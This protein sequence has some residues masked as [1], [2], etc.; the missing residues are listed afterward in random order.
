MELQ[1]VELDAV[2]VHAASSQDGV[3]GQGPGG[4]ST[5]MVVEVVP[6][7]HESV[8]STN[9]AQQTTAF[10]DGNDKVLGKVDKFICQRM[11]A[12]LVEEDWKATF[13]RESMFRSAVQSTRVIM[14]VGVEK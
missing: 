13:G 12:L 10:L 1:T 7:F 9:K 14:D 11:G 8:S 5:S 3:P 2:D 4:Q 6:V